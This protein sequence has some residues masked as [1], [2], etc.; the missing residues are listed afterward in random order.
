MNDQGYEYTPS[1][2]VEEILNYA[3][4]RIAP[5]NY[6]PSG[7]WVFY[8]VYQ[9]FGLAK[10]D[11]KKMDK[12]TSRARKS[13]WNGWRPDTLSDSVRRASIDGTGDD[14]LKEAI[15]DLRDPVFIMDKIRSQENYVEIW[16]EAAAMVGQFTD[17]T[18]GWYITL[19]P[20]R[21][22][23]SV[24]FKYEIAKRLERRANKYGKPVVV[25]YYGDYDPKGLEIPENA[26]KDIRAWCRHEFEFV[27]CGINKDQVADLQIPENPL[28]PGTYQWE[29][30]DDAQARKMILD[31]LGKYWSLDK[32]NEV[33]ED[34]TSLEITWA[35]KISPLID[36][37]L[38][39]Y[40][41]G[42][43]DDEDDDEEDEEDEW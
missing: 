11:A 16:F 8:Q 4:E 36:E 40:G 3:M 20:F 6:A 18:N 13:F 19:V 26:L 21:G 30:M 32:I 33:V 38:E 10:E 28:K 12:W 43:E 25:L 29:A 41:L 1:S 39:E 2:R 9:A 5:L 37:M 34:E 27:R 24:P 17:V 42:D 23:A 31:S 15:E 7:R 14:G 35:E 22:D